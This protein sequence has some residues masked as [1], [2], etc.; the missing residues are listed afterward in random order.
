MSCVGQCCLCSGVVMS[1]V[2]SV[3]V[4]WWCDECGGVVVL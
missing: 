1:V 4:W 3:V 2:M